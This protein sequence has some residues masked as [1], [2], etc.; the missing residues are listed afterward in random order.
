MTDYGI[1]LQHDA[2]DR[3]LTAFIDTYHS[4]VAE[5]QPFP[6]IE[7]GAEDPKWS[8]PQRSMPHHVRPGRDGIADWAKETIGSRL[9]DRRFVEKRRIIQGN[10]A[11]WEGTWEAATTPAEQAAKLPLA[12]VIEFDQ[13]EKVRSLYSY[14]DS[15]HFQ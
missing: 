11:A 10:A 4:T 5:G 3:L 6:W 7:L 1:P 15:A 2:T 8:L 13:E 14:Y 9:R 12:M